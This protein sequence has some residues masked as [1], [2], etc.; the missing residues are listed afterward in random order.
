MTACN[1]IRQ[2]RNCAEC[3]KNR[4]IEVKAEM[5]KEVQPENP[6]RCVDCAHDRM[7]FAKDADC[8]SCLGTGKQSEVPEQELL[9]EITEL[10]LN[11]SGDISFGYNQ[12][13]AREFRDSILTPLAK[14]ILKKLN[15]PVAGEEELKQKIAEILSATYCK[16]AEQGFNA[17]WFSGKTS[18]DKAADQILKLKKLG[19][20]QTDCPAC[21]QSLIE[22]GRKEERE[23]QDD[24]FQMI[25]VENRFIPKG[26][27]LIEAYM[28]QQNELIVLGEPDLVKNHNCDAMGCSTFN[29]V[30]FRRK[31]I[32][33][34]ALRGEG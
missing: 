26:S 5:N 20:K 10:I 30:I 18:F 11:R 27:K 15:K 9:T 34:Q 28:T 29:H 1:C 19:Y 14:D 23:K 21:S 4:L 12:I 13:D 17:D 6:K 31:F 3:L 7:Y 24:E 2:D 25:K 16:G 33:E 32:G 8:Q 22:Q